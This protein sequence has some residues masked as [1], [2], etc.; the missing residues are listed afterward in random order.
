MDNRKKTREFQKKST[1]ASLT[2]LKPLTVWIT[3]DCGKETGEPDHLTCLLRNMY[4]GQEV[5]EL[6]MEKL[7]GKRVWQ[8]C[9]LAPCLFYF[10]AEYIMQ[11]CQAGSITSWNQECWEKYQ[12]PQIYR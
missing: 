4:A 6:D 5:T 3:T 12:Q 11:K 8:G 7:T 10:Y 1:S 2:T 9:I